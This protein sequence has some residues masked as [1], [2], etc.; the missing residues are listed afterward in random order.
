MGR[1]NYESITK[2]DFRFL[3]VKKHDRTVN[4]DAIHFVC[5][6]MSVISCYVLVNMLIYVY[7][8]FTGKE[9]S[10]NKNGKFQN[11]LSTP[12]RKTDY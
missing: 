2:T 4:C 5:F 6:C 10:Y 12:R 11:I 9:F 7:E 8:C 1:N 3:L